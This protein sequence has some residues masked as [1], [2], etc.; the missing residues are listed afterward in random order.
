MP[1]NPW[2]RGTVDPWNRGPVEPCSRWGLYTV[3]PAAA[4]DPAHHRL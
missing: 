1:V 2:T 4:R 3:R